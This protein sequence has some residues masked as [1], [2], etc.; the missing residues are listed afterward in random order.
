MSGCLR[1]CR[2]NTPE[3]AKRLGFQY[4]Y[5]INYENDE[6]SQI[7]TLLKK[8]RYKNITKGTG[9][10]KRLWFINPEHEVYRIMPGILNNYYYPE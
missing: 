7:K 5:F 6:F 8:L 9:K 2:P 10:E 4:K 3:Y 1:N